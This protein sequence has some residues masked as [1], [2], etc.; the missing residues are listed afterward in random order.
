MMKDKKAIADIFT[1]MSRMGYYVFAILIASALFLFIGVLL[2]MGSIDYYK[3]DYGTGAIN[4]EERFFN[5]FAY[6]DEF[7]G[8][9]YARTMDIP[10]IKKI[11]KK[12][13]LD[14]IMGVRGKN[15][16]KGLKVTIFSK[17]KSKILEVSTS[18]YPQTHDSYKK[19]YPIMIYENDKFQAGF[20]EMRYWQP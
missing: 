9:K 1:I 2:K 16:K 5:E 18:N 20:I 15:S 3:S 14:N 11:S 12:Q 10:K 4:L 19:K 6:E 17:E 7:T 8:K 13:Q